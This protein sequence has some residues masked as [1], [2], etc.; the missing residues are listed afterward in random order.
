MKKNLKKC[1][2]SVLVLIL[3]IGVSGCGAQ[4]KKKF[5]RKRAPQEGP[6]QVFV[7]EPK[8]YRPEPN[9]VLY[10]RSFVFWKSWQEELINRLGEN[11]AA[12]VRGFEEVLKNLDEMKGCLKD[13][14][15]A[16]LEM[17][18]KKLYDFYKT[19]KEDDLDKPAAMH[20]Q[21]DLDRL[22]LK[23]DKLFR[24]SRVEKDIK[25]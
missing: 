23:M 24:F 7:Y 22:M 17:Y 11:R 12:D 13:Q 3:C 19:Y 16:E 20:M 6:E 18:R 1:F 15:A 5:V 10:K 14:K 2:H 25:E 21:Q 8:D 4:W 9:P